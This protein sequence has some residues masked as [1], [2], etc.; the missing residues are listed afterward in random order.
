MI[1]PANPRRATAEPVV[2]FQV[3]DQAEPGNV[4]PSLARLL[5]DIDRTGRQ[6]PR[7]ST[8]AAATA[9]ATEAAPMSKTTANGKPRR[10]RGEIMDEMPPN[11]LDSE[12]ALLSGVLYVGNIDPDVTIP[13]HEFYDLRNQAIWETL[14]NLNGEGLRI[15]AA[16][17]LTEIKRHRRWGKDGLDSAYAIDDVGDASGSVDRQAWHADRIHTAYVKRTVSH[18]A[19]FLLQ[20]ARSPCE[21][22]ELQEHLKTLSELL[23]GGTA[24][25]G[26]EPLP[27][28]KLL[29]GGELL[30]LDL[31]P[32][33]LVKGILAEGQPMIE[34][35][36]SK[37][38]K[39]GIA[40]D[41]IVSLGS[42]TPFLGRFDTRK[43][44]VGFWSGESGAATIRDTARRC[45]DARGLS[46][47]DTLTHWSFDLP[48]LS[49]CATWTP[50][51]NHPRARAKGCHSRPVV[52]LPI[53]PRHGQRSEQR[54]L[55]GQPVARVD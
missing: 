18:H 45:A 39:T 38:L 49:T 7:P 42:G 23:A 54:V 22:A 52:S 21:L 32:S 4:V 10:D 19:E 8:T 29:T 40:C 37:T 34:G 47:A 50:R 3:D 15:D 14:V 53:D 1:A 55:D 9:T 26:Q 6:R 41:L 27:F 13:A 5:I 43:V 44:A 11:A 31:R 25:G 28:T 36:R 12:R 24:D 30:N 51:K 48:R 35:G 2:T 46:L 20:K 16:A 17:Y 33:F